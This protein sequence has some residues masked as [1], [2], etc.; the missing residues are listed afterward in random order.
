MTKQTS[1][2]NK[3]HNSIAYLDNASTTK[4]DS[5]V[6]EEMLPYFVEIYG[7]A[8][9][10]HSFGKKAKDA[11][12][13]ARTQVSDLVNCNRQEI[14]FTSGATESINLAIKG[15]VESNAHKGNHLITVKTEHKA[16]LATCEY[17][18]TK[19]YEVTYLDVDENGI[20]S[21]NQLKDSI[22]NDTLLIT[23]M[24]VNNETGV[25]QPI[26]EIG[27][28]CKEK[29]VAF[30]CDAT[31]ALGKIEVD[32]EEDSIDMLCFSGHKLNGPKGI[33][34]LYKRNDIEISPLIHGGGQEYGLRG[35]TY[36]TP[37]IVGLGK[38]CEIAKLEYNY[39]IKELNKKREGIEKYYETNN[40][41]KV[42]FKNVRKAPHIISITLK[43]YEAEEFLMLNSKEFMAS[44]GSAC[45][46]EIIEPSHVLKAIGIQSPEKVIRL[47]IEK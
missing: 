14:I 38:S 15:Y 36:N 17:L 30:F 43:D 7:N 44:T 29:Q 25:I 11:I 16:V 28:L 2:Y 18:E 4:V 41:G 13:N 34:V 32:V 1:E 46:A 9:S 24:Y 26:K 39:N 42:N 8:S 37:L 22:R 31:Q 40:V 27:S 47:S 19:G 33:G 5:R 20:I 23:V 35:G 45:N 3:S 21:M 12:D 10:N 6:L